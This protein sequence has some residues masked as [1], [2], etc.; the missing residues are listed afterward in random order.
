MV[1][2]NGNLSK[3]VGAV[4]AVI[5]PGAAVGGGIYGPGLV[6]DVKFAVEVGGMSRIQQ[7]DSRI[8]SLQVMLDQ[9]VRN[10]DPAQAQAIRQYIADLTQQK[11]RIERK[12]SK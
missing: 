6:D 12:M 7:I 2:I 10:N 8:I 1:K 11:R 5:V 9:A 3:I 4:L